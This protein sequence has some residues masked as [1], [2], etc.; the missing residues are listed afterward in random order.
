MK[1]YSPLNDFIRAMSGSRAKGVRAYMELPD[2][3]IGVS[4]YYS[5]DVLDM[6]IKEQTEAGCKLIKKENQ[7]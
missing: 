1:N 3:K 5:P 2:G 6:F 4:A 7:K